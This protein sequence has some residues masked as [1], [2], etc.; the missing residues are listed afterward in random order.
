MRT[1]RSLLVLSLL[2]FAVAGVGP[3][4]VQE[5]DLGVGA[6]EVGQDRALL[7]THVVPVD[8]DRPVNFRVQVA[9]D[10]GFTQIVRMQAAV[11]RPKHDFTVRVLVPGLSPATLE[12]VSVMMQKDPGSR[13]QSPQEIIDHLEG[14]LDLLDPAKAGVGKQ[15]AVR[16][17]RRRAR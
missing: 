9:L 6:F 1:T 2:A 12:L 10:P 3:C 7:W 17:R 13:H 5:F 15:P 16:R 11:A 8:P 14:A 4:G